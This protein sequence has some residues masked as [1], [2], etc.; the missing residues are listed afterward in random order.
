MAT[1]DIFNGD[2]FSLTS[3]SGAVENTDYKPG[4]LLVRFASREK[5]LQRNKEVKQQ[6]L[7]SLGGAKIKKA[8]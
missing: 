7:N 3:L 4:Y 6:I 5:G 2:G 8:F 1:L